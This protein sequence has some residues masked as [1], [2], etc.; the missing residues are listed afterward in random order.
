EWR[1]VDCALAGAYL[2]EDS[3]S[4]SGVLEFFFLTDPEDFIMTHFPMS[5]SSLMVQEGLQM[6]AIPEPYSQ[7]SCRAILSVFA[8]ETA[9]ELTSHPMAQVSVTKCE[10]FSFRSEQL[11][12]MAA[13]LRERTSGFKQK[14]CIL[15]TRGGKNSFRVVVKPKVKGE[16]KLSVSGQARNAI[17]DSFHLLVNYYI[18]VITVEQ[19]FVPLPEHSGAWGAS[20]QALGCGFSDRIFRFDVLACRSGEVYIKL[21][22][23]RFVSSRSSVTLTREGVDREVTSDGGGHDGQMTL[24]QYTEGVVHIRAR[25]S[26]RGFHRLSLLAQRYDVTDDAS[27]SYTNVA[28]FLIHSQNTSMVTASFPKIFPTAQGY[29]CLL[30]EP[31]VGELALNE[32]VLIRLKSTLL[33]RVKVDGLSM[34]RESAGDRDS[35]VWCLQYTP[36]C[37]G[38]SVYIYGGVSP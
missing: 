33:T 7:F 10:T 9:L 26:E 17:D 35:D 27:S 6:L 38:A 8:Q 21:P 32:P 15:C 37:P 1:F 4:R 12:N 25:F 36:T 30:L 20:P 5:M 28:D 18:T 31:L 11:Q 3:M 13:V 29:R 22:T 23:T 16:F 19:G 34:R 14:H 24:N 2:E